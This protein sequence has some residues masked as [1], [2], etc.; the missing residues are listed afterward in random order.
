MDNS[1]SKINVLYIITG[2]AC[3]GAEVQLSTLT[4]SLN[5][6]ENIR[7]KV[8]SIAAINEISSRFK[9]VDLEIIPINSLAGVLKLIKSALYFKPDIIHSHMIHSNIIGM[10]LSLLCRCSCICTAH[11]TVEGGKLLLNLF[12]FLAW[13][14]KPYI[15]HVSSKGSDIYKKNFLLK[16]INIKQYINPIDFSSLQQK[17]SN[18][19][20]QNSV[21][22]WVC[23][24]SL[25][26]QKNHQRLLNSF[27]L[28]LASY[29]NDQLYIIGDGPERSFLESYAKSISLNDSVFFCGKKNNLGVI[30]KEF[31]FFVLSSDW[32]G[33]PVALI[34][35]LYVG[36]PSLVTNCGD[37]E[38][39][40]T[41]NKNGMIVDLNEADS[42][43]HDYMLN[44]RKNNGSGYWDTVVFCQKSVEIFNIVNIKKYW[45]KKYFESINNEI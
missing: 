39:V 16:N 40:I 27:K 17:T 19:G 14:T 35:A 22:K 9:N 8:I 21:R 41:N 32:E 6:D 24:A 1:K 2:L 4:N 20:D 10:I 42:I 34:E 37:I 11:N 18:L 12:Y 36:L 38:K 23:V 44:M 43:F 13:I 7:V 15:Y 45:I 3:G 31:D 28:Y 33:L 30:L 29:P 5:Q 26:K 25:T